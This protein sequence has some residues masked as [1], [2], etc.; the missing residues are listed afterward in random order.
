[1]TP[2]PPIAMRLLRVLVPMLFAML[3]VEPAS[4]YLKFGVTIGGRVVTIKWEDLPVRYF[5]N[6]RGVANVTAN[7]LADALARAFGT[8]EAVPTAAIRY[9]FGGFTGAL[10]DVDDGRS[11][12]GFLARPELERV[13]ASTSLLI[14]DATGELLETDIFFNSAFNWST[15]A[16]GE[17]GR[18]DVETI[19]LHEIGHLNGLGHSAIGE[20]EMSATGRRVLAAEAA[21]FPLAYGS[22][23]T[24]HRT[25]R[26]DDIAAI[27]DVYPDGDVEDTTGSISGRVVKNGAG[28]FGAH[29][30]AFN[31][32]TGALVGN[33]ALNNNGNFSIAGLTPGPHIVRV[34]PLDDAD[35]DSFFLVTAPLDL[36]FRAAFHDKVIVAPRGGDSGSIEIRVV[37]K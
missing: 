30:V 27:S 5:V 18:F 28:V 4:A 33:F 12:I 2:N 15:S 31:L 3:V 19:A 36:N 20:T 23:N 11:T 1:V 34:E 10:P 6:D 25:L 22:G 14:D 35:V 7:A 29:V 37:P 9:Q 21:M 26:A 8:W 32:T 13:L 16:T 17:A 24:S